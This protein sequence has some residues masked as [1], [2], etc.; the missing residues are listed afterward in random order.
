[1]EAAVTEE[2]IARQPAETQAIIRALLAQIAELKARIE[3]LERQVNG[4]TPQDSSL[5]PSSQHPHVRPQPPRCKAKKQRGGQRRHEKHARRSI[6]T[7][8]CDDV[9]SLWPTE[10]RRFVARM[11]TV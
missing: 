7:D 6:P 5:P 4:K 9:Q 1:M 10:C 11:F 2:S 8:Q 3:E